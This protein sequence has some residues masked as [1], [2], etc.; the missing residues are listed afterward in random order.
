M[1]QPRVGAPIRSES[2]LLRRSPK[3]RRQREGRAGCLI[4]PR[5]AIPIHYEGWKHFRQGRQEIERELAR[6]PEDVRSRIQWLPIGVEV[7][8][9]AW[10]GSWR[11]RGRNLGSVSRGVLAH[12]KRPVLI[13]RAVTA[14][15]RVAAKLEP[16]AA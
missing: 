5:T 13:V 1:G 6:A 14:V 10:G 8:I 16:L 4:R 11:V 9:A 3:R 7:E 2:I 15:E 12:S